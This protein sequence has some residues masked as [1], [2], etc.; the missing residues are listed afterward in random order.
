MGSLLR[1]GDDVQALCIFSHD[2]QDQGCQEE[3]SSEESTNIVLKFVFPGGSRPRGIARLI[4]K[5]LY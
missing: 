5:Y 1:V 4:I 2:K 3:S